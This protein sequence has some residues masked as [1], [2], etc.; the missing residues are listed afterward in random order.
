[1]INK[2]GKKKKDKEMNQRDDESKKTAKKKKKKKKIHISAQEG[3]GEGQIET[4]G[5]WR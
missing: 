4:K 2:R 5:T 3:M 1:M